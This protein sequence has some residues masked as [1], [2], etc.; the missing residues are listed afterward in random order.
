MTTPSLD[1]KALEVSLF[2]APNMTP[3]KEITKVQTGIHFLFSKPKKIHAAS[4]ATTTVQ[5][6]ASPSPF[7]TDSKRDGI[8]Q[9]GILS[10][11]RAK[12]QEDINLAIRRMDNSFITEDLAAKILFYLL[13][14]AYRDGLIKDWNGKGKEKKIEFMRGLPHI[15]QFLYRM[16]IEPNVNILL[17][18]LNFEFHYWTNIASTEKSLE[19]IQVACRNLQNEDSPFRRIIL[20]ALQLT[21][22]VRKA[23]TEKCIPNEHVMPKNSLKVEHL[24]KLLQVKSYT[25]TESTLLH[26]L[27][28]I[29]KCQVDDESLISKFEIEVKKNVSPI[30]GA[31]FGAL[32]KTIESLE[33]GLGY[34]NT[35]LETN[36]I[37]NTLRAVGDAPGTTDE[38]KPYDTKAVDKMKAYRLHIQVLEQSTIVANRKLKEE[39]SSEQAEVEHQKI[40]D[41][42]DELR[43]TNERLDK[44]I[45]NRGRVQELIELKAS[46]E[47][48]LV[49]CKDA[50]E[51]AKAM[52][53]KTAEWFGETIEEMRSNETKDPGRFMLTIIE[54]LR[55]I[56]LAGGEKVKITEAATAAGLILPASS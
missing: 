31:E 45:K 3:I 47:K 5:T 53:I 9:I 4:T 10:P 23:P 55:L 28:V 38:Y 2:D 40:N 1:G 44:M 27:I 46:A 6:I 17:E 41:N 54:F 51:A 34:L 33:S 50:L 21:N 37:L 30:A 52:F 32:E 15:H 18:V 49:V 25:P 11:L 8:I 22:E 19:T 43:Q 20:I 35:L 39:C 56:K 48:R 42:Q 36:E 14:K 24:Q 13:D 26:Y 29:I 7:E 16:S 12:S